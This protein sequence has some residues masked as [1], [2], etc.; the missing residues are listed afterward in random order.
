MTGN[1][2]PEC[3]RS[4]KIKEERIAE[5]EKRVE[6]KYEQLSASIR[7]LTEC[8]KIMKSEHQQSMIDKALFDK[9]LG[10]AEDNIEKLWVCSHDLEDKIDI[11]G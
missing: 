2:V 1:P 6:E 3:C 8:V 11:R 4:H 9:R 10:T 7:E 5:R